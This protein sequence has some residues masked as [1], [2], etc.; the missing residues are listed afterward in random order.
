MEEARE[1]EYF[2]GKAKALFGLAQAAFA[3]GDVVKAQQM[4]QESLASYKALGHNEYAMV[5]A[6]LTEISDP[7]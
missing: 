6:W 2:A 3:Q 5:A 4:G 1:I 7:K